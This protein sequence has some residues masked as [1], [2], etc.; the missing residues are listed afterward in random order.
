MHQHRVVELQHALGRDSRLRWF[1]RRLEHVADRAHQPAP[2][3]PRV[4][5]ERFQLETQQAPA[6]RVR[7][8]DEHVR[9]EHRERREQHVPA[10]GAPDIVDL[11]ALRIHEGAVARIRDPGGGKRDD[12]D[13][14][15]IDVRHSCA[16]GDECNVSSTLGDPVRDGGG[17]AQMADPHQ[18]LNPDHDPGR[19]LRRGHGRR[20]RPAR[21]GVECTTH[22]AAEAVTGNYPSR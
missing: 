10:G 14:I 7:L 17:T 5:D 8:G 12:P 15:G 4:P 18:M 3:G 22:A 13:P 20:S 11:A 2:R 16:A 9:R 21:P 19:G 6:E 1:R